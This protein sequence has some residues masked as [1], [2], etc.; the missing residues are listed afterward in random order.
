MANYSLHLRTYLSIIILIFESF[1][2]LNSIYCVVKNIIWWYDVALKVHI[3]ESWLRKWVITR[4][5]VMTHQPND[6][7]LLEKCLNIGLTNFSLTSLLRPNPSIWL[8]IKFTFDRSNCQNKNSVKSHDDVIWQKSLFF[9]DQ[10]CQVKKSVKSHDD[11]I[12]QKILLWS[13]KLSK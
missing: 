13:M 2:I 7:I 10:N 12:W 4:L 6:F 8:H 11:V 5:K 1:L 3:A 9:V